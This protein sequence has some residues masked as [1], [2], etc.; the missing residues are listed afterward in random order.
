MNP[1][2]KLSSDPHTNVV[3]LIPT[4]IAHYTHNNIFNDKV[5]GCL[6]LKVRDADTLQV[7]S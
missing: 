2:S 7:K 4:H 1:D 3:A 6:K 5:F